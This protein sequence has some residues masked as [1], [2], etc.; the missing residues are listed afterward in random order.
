VVTGA[1]SAD[2]FFGKSAAPELECPPGP[3][4]SAAR[5]FEEASQAA[6][7]LARPLGAVKCRPRA[8]RLPGARRFV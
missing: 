6:C 7:D 3:I 2:Q 4:R 5:M 8:A 1:S